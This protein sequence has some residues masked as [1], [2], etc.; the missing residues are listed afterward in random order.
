MPEVVRIE[1]IPDCIERTLKAIN[2]GVL[3]ANAAGL[4]TEMPTEVPFKMVVIKDWQALESESIQTGS[5]DEIQGGTTKETA[6]KDDR[7]TS[8]KSGAGRKDN[9]NSHVGNSAR[10]VRNTQD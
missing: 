4:M 8:S 5:S 7:A 10:N 1:E 9:R 3:A 2:A 6:E